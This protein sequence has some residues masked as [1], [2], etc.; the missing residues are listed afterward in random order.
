MRCA[1]CWISDCTICL[2]ATGEDVIWLLRRSQ[3]CKGSGEGTVSTRHSS[4]LSIECCVSFFFPPHLSPLLIHPQSCGVVG[5]ASSQNRLNR[6][7][8]E[9]HSLWHGG[10]FLYRNLLHARPSGDVPEHVHIGDSVGSTWEYTALAL[11]ERSFN[12]AKIL[13]RLQ[14]FV[15]KRETYIGL[16]QW[17]STAL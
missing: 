6:I 10:A 1:Y 7:D 14:H 17:A 9:P 4:P 2:L 11:S 13:F 12:P 3:C 8:T 16:P 15:V 5:S